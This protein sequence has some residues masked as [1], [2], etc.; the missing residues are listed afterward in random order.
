MRDLVTQLH[1]KFPREY[2]VETLAGFLLVQLGHIPVEGESVDFNSR[3]FEVV[4]MDGQRIAQV[5]VDPIEETE[6]MRGAAAERDQA[7]AETRL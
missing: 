4:K 7:S 6:A 2:G 1:W 5:R 3:R